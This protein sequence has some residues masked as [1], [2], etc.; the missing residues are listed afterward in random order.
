MLAGSFG[1]QL[2][3]CG[4]GRGSQEDELAVAVQPEQRGYADPHD[5]RGVE[6]DGVLQLHAIP[7]ECH[8]ALLDANPDNVEYH[9]RHGLV[10]ETAALAVLERPLPV[11]EECDAR[12]GAVRDEDGRHLA[13]AEPVVQRVLHAELHHG[14]QGANDT[15]LSDLVQ[16]NPEPAIAIS[17]ETQLGAS[18]RVSPAAFGLPDR[19]C[20]KPFSTS[21]WGRSSRRRRAGARDLPVLYRPS[22]SST[23]ATR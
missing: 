5:R 10:G 8:E 9:E 4:A 2:L 3:Q 13:N 22:L 7:H 12:R 16:Q 23:L 21:P 20:P 19:R 6:R 14:T 15:E 17:D 11:A 1:L 18:S